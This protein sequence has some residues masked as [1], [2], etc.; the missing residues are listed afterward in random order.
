M[1]KVKVTD[2]VYETCPIMNFLTKNP[3]IILT[4]LKL[5]S[6]STVRLSRDNENIFQRKLR[7]TLPKIN[8]HSASK[9]YIPGCSSLFNNNSSIRL[10]PIKPSVLRHFRI[11]NF[12][13]NNVNSG[14]RSFPSITKCNMKRCCTCKYIDCRSTIKSSVN[15]R[16]FSINIPT[17][18]N[19]LSSNIIY[20]ITWTRNN[21]GIQYVGQTG[22]HLKVRFREHLYKIRNAKKLKKFL[23]NHFRITGHTINDVIIQPLEYLV[24]DQTATKGFIIQARHNAE[25]K[26]IRN[27]QTP[28]PLGLNDNIYRDGNIS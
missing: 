21:C 12:G 2:N 20:A 10:S 13:L 4:P 11:N 6:V 19:W 25:L 26:R 3:K 1:S 5:H 27:L 22:R 23:Y 17:D 24:F 14:Y 9:F 16:V 18:V 15:G 8:L 28:Y 7:I